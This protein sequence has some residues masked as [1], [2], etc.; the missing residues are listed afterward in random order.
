MTNTNPSETRRAS[1]VRRQAEVLREVIERAEDE[2]IDGGR[3]ADTMLRGLF[4]SRRELGSRDRRLIGDTVFAFF[5][6][7]GWTRERGLDPAASCA[8]A[9]RLDGEAPPPPVERFAA[10]CGS[11]P[12]GRVVPGTL[13]ERRAA[14]QETLRA[15]PPLDVT[16]LVPAWAG[17]QLG[18]IAPEGVAEIIESFQDRPPTWLRVRPNRADRVREALAAQGIEFAEG[19]SEALAIEGGFHLGELRKKAGRTFEVQDLAS[20]CVGAVCD[21]R[22]G[23]AWWDVCAGAGGKA[24]HLAD[25]MEGQGR[26]LATDR[27]EGIVRNLK[28]RARASGMKSVRAAVLDAAARVPEERFDG[29]LIDAPCSGMGTW[30]RNPDARWRTDG[31]MPER[32]REIQRALLQRGA[33]ALRPGG[34]LVYSVCTLTSTETMEVVQDL[35]EARDDLAPEAFP[36]PLGG[37]NTDGAAWVLPQDGPCS[38]MFIAR[39]RK[40]SF[41]E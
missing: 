35:L 26:V 18:R 24:L 11:D 34:I 4:R 19:P 33:E 30:S 2:V 10:E 41:Y 23:E 40:E 37:G 9:W 1:I 39:L 16:E 27:R 8:V 6:W 12:G 3:P 25:R 17:E 36:H 20:Q 14:L 28:Q 15:N 32:K 31:S 22:P 29:V 7:R 21:P 5:R 38:G 13:E